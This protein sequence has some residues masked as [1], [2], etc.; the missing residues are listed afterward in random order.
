MKNRLGRKAINHSNI[1]T[2]FSSNS[3]KSRA[4]SSEKKITKKSFI[5]QKKNKEQLNNSLDNS[6][7]Q[8][9]AFFKVILLGDLGV[10]KTTLS[11][12]FLKK[13][14]KTKTLCQINMDF[15][16]KE[17]IIDNTIVELQIW[18]TCGQEEYSAL[19]KQFYRDCNGCLMVFDLSNNKSFENLQKWKEELTNRYSNNLP[20]VIVGNKKDKVVKENELSEKAK[21]MAKDNNY[22][23]IETSAIQ[24]INVKNVF[25]LIARMMLEYHKNKNKDDDSFDE[26]EERKRRQ[27]KKGEITM[28]DSY[29]D[30]EENSKSKCC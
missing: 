1:K 3:K 16:S 27:T 12:Q 21:K 29:F 19:T 5:E 11:S 18:D 2:T 30:D 24:M 25:R 26:G 13:F 22:E 10:G 23:Y 15:N 8:I 4:K 7:F 6:Q 20:V 14:L 28:V 9:R 17:L